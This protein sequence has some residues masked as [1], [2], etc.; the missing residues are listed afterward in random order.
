MLFV[1]LSTT[2][3]VSIPLIHPVQSSDA[4][5]IGENPSVSAD[6]TDGSIYRA[7]STCD[8]TTLLWEWT[9]RDTAYCDWYRSIETVRADAVG[10][11]P[12]LR[13]SFPK[14]T[15]KWDFVFAEAP[16]IDGFHARLIA[17]EKVDPTV[18][19]VDAF[20]AES[21]FDL[22]AVAKFVVVAVDDQA[23]EYLVLSDG[24]H[25]VRIDIAHGSV[26]AGPVT[27]KLHCKE[28]QIVPLAAETLTRAGL[29]WQHQRMPSARFPKD[30]KLSR[31]VMALR[32]Y[33]ALHD[34]AHYR[35]IAR[36]LF[37]DD[38]VEREWRG[39]SD[40]LRA[41][42]RRIAKQAKQLAAGGYHNIMRQ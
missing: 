20:P 2:M 8:R 35:D 5:K 23:R 32:V 15:N 33:D 11:V 37:G 22:A 7:I 13:Q 41:T 24:H 34:E 14:R 16:S 39:D 6:W 30:P 12:V 19:V 4:V 17:S 26:L 29:V 9:R 3:I 27:F 10:G 21:G 40:S 31:L 42:I 18:I 36:A 38:R 1:S 28:P 25:H